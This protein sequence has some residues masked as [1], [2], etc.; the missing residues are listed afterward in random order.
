MGEKRD[1]YRAV[2]HYEEKYEKKEIKI[3]RKQRRRM[4]KGNRE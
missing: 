3:G 4:G 2:I 1:K